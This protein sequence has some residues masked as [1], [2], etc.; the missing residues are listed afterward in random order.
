MFTIPYTVKATNT[1]TRVNRPI[2]YTII[3]TMK[4]N[5][6]PRD[7][8]VA[9]QSWI[10]NN[11]EYDY[12]FFD[13]ARCVR[14]IKNNYDNNILT[15]FMVINTGAGK[16]DFFRW[17]YLYKKGGI[18]V[19]IDAVCKQSI[20]GYGVI[21]NESFICQLGNEDEVLSRPRWLNHLFL[22]CSKKLPI[23][24]VAIDIALNRINTA[25]RLRK[26]VVLTPE[27]V[28]PGV[29]GTALNICLNLPPRRPRK[30]HNYRH[31]ING[32]TH[33]L[34][35]YSNLKLL[36]KAKY[37]NYKNDFEKMS[38]VN[39]RETNAFIF[40]KCQRYLNSQSIDING[41]NLK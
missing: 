23:L 3:Q 7:M 24:K 27:L 13:D 18:Y 20:E 26:D 30:Y 19:D 34:I 12:E 39:Y 4:T 40:R 31:V 16:A 15:K 35:A 5:K 17:L 25:Y 38:L 33:R 8:F 41:N 10:K 37:D 29:L 21:S 32:K 14:F 2:P 36:Y 11:P 28:G 1:A 22:C 6:V 9:S